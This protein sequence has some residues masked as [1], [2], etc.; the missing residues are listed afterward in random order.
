MCDLGFNFGEYR[1]L[2]CDLICSFKL[3][4]STRLI[5]GR[6]CCF[7]LY[8]LIFQEFPALLDDYL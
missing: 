3:R 4:L 6:F 1:L 2:V 5:F 7:C 8:D